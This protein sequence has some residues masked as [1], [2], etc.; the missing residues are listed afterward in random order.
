MLL[1]NYQ[2]SDC[3]EIMELF[4]N[5]VHVINARDYSP[6]QLNAWAPRELDEGR[7]DRSFKEHYTLVAVEN[8]KIVGF[9]DI[10]SMGCSTVGWPFLFG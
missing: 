6:D 2:S 4:Y 7:W 1:R 3:G 8:S 5:T 10:D 9:G